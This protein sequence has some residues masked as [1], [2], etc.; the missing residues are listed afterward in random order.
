MVEGQKYPYLIWRLVL[1]A[2]SRNLKFLKIVV[3]YCLSP[4]LHPR[5]SQLSDHL[6]TKHDV[7]FLAA[8]CL[9]RPRALLLLAS[10]PVAARSCCLLPR[11]TAF[12]WSSSSPENVLK[13]EVL[14]ENLTNDNEAYNDD[15]DVDNWPQ[16]QLPLPP[17]LLPAA[18][19]SAMAGTSS[20]NFT[21]LG[22][23]PRTEDPSSVLI[24]VKSQFGLENGDEIY[25]MMMMDGDD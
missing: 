22:S 8:P 10:S 21:P 15:N 2:A 9:S 25:A 24:S 12:L 14:E 18:P 4:S 11:L 19:T 7:C 3:R 17:P 20:M 5:S 6:L 1:E 13:W 16:L 23:R